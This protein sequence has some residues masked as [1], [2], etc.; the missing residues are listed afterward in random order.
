MKADHL[1]SG[2]L[3]VTLLILLLCWAGQTS[4]YQKE[5]KESLT[6][7]LNE[8]IRTLCDKETLDSNI[9]LERICWKARMK[10]KNTLE[11]Q[12]VLSATLLPN[13]KKLV[14]SQALSVL[15]GTQIVVP[16]PG[17]LLPIL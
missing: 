10:L 17:F 6:L 12:I 8:D 4:R 15:L 5:R 9:V 3:W 2:R 7:V 16:V 14:T 11:F 1:T 13:S